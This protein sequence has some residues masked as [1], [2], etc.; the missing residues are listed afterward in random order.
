[1]IFNYRTRPFRER[2]DADAV[3]ARA[4]IQAELLQVFPFGLGKRNMA[5]YEGDLSQYEIFLELKEAA[6]DEW[7]I[8]N[9]ETGKGL[10]LFF[11]G[12]EN[13][14][15]LLDSL[16]DI[17]NYEPLIKT[18]AEGKKI[19]KDEASLLTYLS[20]NKKTQVGRDR[21]LKW[22]QQISEQYPEFGALFKEKLLGYVELKIA[23][24]TD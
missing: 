21:L 10:N 23:E 14:K 11:Y 7:L 16:E 20:N 1:M 12:D 3:A 19:Y 22:G 24:E 6:N 9:S 5:T 4:E 18:T 17:K 13:N 2:N 8:E 15:G